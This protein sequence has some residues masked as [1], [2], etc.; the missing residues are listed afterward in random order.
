MNVVPLLAG[1][2]GGGVT[3]ADRQFVSRFVFARPGW[4]VADRLH[5]QRGTCLEISYDRPNFYP[6]LAWRLIRSNSYIFVEGTDS[7]RNTG[8]YNNA[9]EALLV[10]WEDSE[11]LV[12]GLQAKST[13][14]L[15]GLDPLVAGDI[16]DIAAV[17]GFE[18]LVVAVDAMDLAMG[19][20]AHLAA[21]VV[22]LQLHPTGADGRDIIR[23]LRQDRPGLPVLAL[24]VHAPTAPEADLHGLG[25]PTHR[26]Q[27]PHDA[28]RVLHWLLDIY[29]KQGDGPAEG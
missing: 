11:R 21:A 28:D 3:A 29:E 8:P 12:A 15:C 7:T 24:T 5:P 27:R 17:A 2:H 19:A 25:G 16:Q 9:H 23:R 1:K 26:E 6:R 13:I 10:I 20:N 18:T 22:D 14:V 4:H